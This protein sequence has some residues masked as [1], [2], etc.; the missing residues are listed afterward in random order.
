MNGYRCVSLC[1]F[2]EQLWERGSPERRGPEPRKALV[3]RERR[4]GSRGR[5]RDSL[6]IGVGEIG[7]FQR[8]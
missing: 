4:V 2:K 5:L 6:L 7:A 8:Q 3:S 1:S